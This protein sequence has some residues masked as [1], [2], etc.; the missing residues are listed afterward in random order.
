MILAVDA[1]PWYANPVLL[2]AICGLA[3][4]LLGGV[5]T[6]VSSYIL[7]QKRADHERLREER[8]EAIDIRRAARCRENGE[9]NFPVIRSPW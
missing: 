6:A 2:P 1:F 7:D 9:Q 8:K 3:G 4:V 5:L